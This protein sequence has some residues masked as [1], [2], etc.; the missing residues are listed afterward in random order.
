MTGREEE[1]WPAGP[2]GLSRLSHCRTVPGPEPRRRVD[3]L[4]GLVS[5]IERTGGSW[6]SRRGIDGV[7][8]LYNYRW[9]ADP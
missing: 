2:K 3:Y 7:Q 8:R 5:S 1:K 9:D 6:R 4:R